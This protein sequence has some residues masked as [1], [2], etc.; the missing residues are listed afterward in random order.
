MLLNKTRVKDGN[1]REIKKYLETNENR[2]RTYQNLWDAAKARAKFIWINTYIKEESQINNL[3]LH[4][5]ELGKEEQS[6]IRV[7]RRKKIQRP[8]RKHTRD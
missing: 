2:N 3:T 5:E 6:K 4:F 7:G 1:K 8:E